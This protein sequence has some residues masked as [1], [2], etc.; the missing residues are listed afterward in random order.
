M[1]TSARPTEP[2]ELLFDVPTLSPAVYFIAV[3]TVAPTLETLAIIYIVNQLLVATQGHD[4][5]KLYCNKFKHPGPFGERWSDIINH[6][7]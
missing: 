1:S 3:S 4:R 2:Y 7:R 6:V 5:I